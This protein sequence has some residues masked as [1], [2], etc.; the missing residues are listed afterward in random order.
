MAIQNSR[1]LSVACRERFTIP[2][3]LGIHGESTG[4]R[5]QK[6]RCGHSY[7]S[8]LEEPRSSA[9]SFWRPIFVPNE[10]SDFGIFVLDISRSSVLS[11]VHPHYPYPSLSFLLYS[12]TGTTQKF[13]SNSPANET[14]AAACQQQLIRNLLHSNIQLHAEN[15]SL[16]KQHVLQK[17]FAPA[18][19]LKQP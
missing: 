14:F 2:K 1:L 16:S 19:G 6:T 13:A 15:S 10:C 8:E 11:S 5:F 3:S 9:G 4:T 17:E 12:Q 18:T 7:H